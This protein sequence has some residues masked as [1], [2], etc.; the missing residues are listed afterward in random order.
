[1]IKQVERVEL[2][3][4]KIKMDIR[5][6]NDV[7]KQL[8]ERVIQK[9]MSRNHNSSEISQAQKLLLDSIRE[10][11]KNFQMIMEKLKEAQIE[12]DNFDENFKEGGK[13]LPTGIFIFFREGLMRMKILLNDLII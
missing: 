3:M 4:N 7:Q 12:L 10:S 2:V 9:L 8:F 11:P 6:L 5:S 1:M 13:S